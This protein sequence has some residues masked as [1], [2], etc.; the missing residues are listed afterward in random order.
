MES[1]KSKALYR[2]LHVHNS[3]TK[4]IEEFK[5]IEQGKVRW[6]LCGPTVYDEAHLG[7]AKAYMQSDT[8][9][10]IMRD[11]FKYDVQL[12]MNITDVD[13]KII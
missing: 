5:T 1:N 4:Q 9:K 11:Y 7:H 3:L 2:T 10:R 6:Y 8:L 12:V 13:D